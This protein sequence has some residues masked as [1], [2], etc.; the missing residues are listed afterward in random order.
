MKVLSKRVVLHTQEKKTS[1]AIVVL[2]AHCA[3]YP[4]VTYTIF[5]NTPFIQQVSLMCWGAVRRLEERGAVGRLAL[6]TGLRTALSWMSHD[7]G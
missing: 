1:P 3:S 5:S 6:A 2:L 7:L 4:V